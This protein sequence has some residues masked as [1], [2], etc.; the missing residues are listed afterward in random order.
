MIRNLQCCAVAFI[1]NLN[2]D[3]LSIR[4]EDFERYMSG[5]ATPHDPSRVIT[6][7]DG[8]RL[9]RQNVTALVELRQRQER[10]MAEAMQLQQDM[11]DFCNS[12]RDQVRLGKIVISLASNLPSIIP[13]AYIEMPVDCHQPVSCLE[14]LR[15]NFCR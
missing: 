1:E 13:V 7:C 10:L 15:S 11:V 5:A 14:G 9:M 4:V 3:S 8:L 12:T 6:S 2:A